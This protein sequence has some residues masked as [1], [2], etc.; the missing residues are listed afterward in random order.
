VNI[1][2]GLVA[3][4]V[5]GP[6]TGLDTAPAVSPA[7]MVMVIAATQEINTDL[8]TRCLPAPGAATSSSHP[9]ASSVTALTAKPLVLGCNAVAVHAM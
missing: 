4:N 9:E 1:D 5:S 7:P 8:N 6:N 3:T 2:T